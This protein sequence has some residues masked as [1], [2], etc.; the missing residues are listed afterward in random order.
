[1]T[2]INELALEQM[3]KTMEPTAFCTLERL[4]QWKDEGGSGAYG[5]EKLENAMKRIEKTRCKVVAGL[6]AYFETLR[7]ESLSL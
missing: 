4:R 7:N 6:T 3:L 5:L 2:G 1:M